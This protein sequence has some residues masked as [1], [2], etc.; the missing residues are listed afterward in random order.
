MRPI[1]QLTLKQSTSLRV[2]IEVQTTNYE[3]EEGFGP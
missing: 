3:D 1:Q 2:K